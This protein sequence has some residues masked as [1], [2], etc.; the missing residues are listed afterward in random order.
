MIYDKIAVMSVDQAI[1]ATAYSTDEIDFGAAGLDIG[2]GNPLILH[3][4]LTTG[5]TTSANTLT[6]GEVSGA[7]TA[8]TTQ[9]STVL[10]A[11]ATSALTSPQQLVRKSLPLGLAR[12]Y[13]LV[14]TV[15]TTL[16]TGTV[17]AFISLDNG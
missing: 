12:Y 1:T 16:A 14:Y 11:T 3:I 17:T 10:E 8:P 5:F 9:V 15:S 13:R 7:A 2:Q 6:I 4:F